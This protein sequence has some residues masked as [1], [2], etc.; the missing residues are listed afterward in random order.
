MDAED[1]T[2]GAGR[3]PGEAGEA[4]NLG[5]EA[6][7]PA[8][9]LCPKCG[10]RLQLL[11][12]ACQKCGYEASP[13]RPA[14]VADFPW[15]FTALLAAL[16]CF[17]TIVLAIVFLVQGELGVALF[18]CPVAFFIQVVLLVVSVRAIRATPLDKP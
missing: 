7:E 15:V 2:G 17:L 14:H 16:G 8:H 9:A 13:Q 1:L 3:M 4:P 11:D 10:S 6:G 18:G 12:L 5:A